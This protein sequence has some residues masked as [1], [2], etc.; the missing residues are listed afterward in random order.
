MKRREFLIRSPI[1]PSIPMS[2]KA[3][4]VSSARFLL[5]VGA[6]A[7]SVA[8]IGFGCGDGGTETGDVTGPATAASAAVSA[9]KAGHDDTYNRRGN[10]L[11]SDQY[12]NR[13]IEVS[14]SGRIVWQFGAGPADLNS[15]NSPVGVNDAQ[16]VGELTLVAGTGN[17]GGF[18]DC[19]PG[20][21]PDNR[22]M[23][24]NQE[25]KV[26][27]QYGQFAVSGSGPNELDTPVQATWLPNGHVLITDQA[28][29]RVIEVTR[30]RQIA[31]QYG[32]TGGCVPPDSLADNCLNNPNS[33]ELLENGHILIADENNSRV[34]EVNRAH[35]IVA[36]YS[37]G[38]TANVVAFASRLQN[39]HTLITDAGNARAVEVD[40]TDNIVWQCSTNGDA[41]SNPSPQPSRAI[42][43][44]NGNTIISDQYNNRV[45]VVDHQMPCNIVSSFGLPLNA[46]NNTGFG[47]DNAN[48]GLNGP[49]DAKVNGDFTGL[50]APRGQDS[51]N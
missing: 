33:A 43:L 21:C 35:H 34:I 45:F 28:N 51:G 46:G 10:T 23:L 17:P 12:N 6:A 24:V 25:K 16:R 22:V 8:L 49:Y 4:M 50:T 27:W 44:A 32:V 13:V 3:P 31:W 39:G 1:T 18:G 36:T 47:T 48:Q 2:S 37:A 38:G 42:R 30:E 14:P 29:A 5:A 11:I 15:G 19:N 40:A 7:I 20:P 9:L 26:L 41:N